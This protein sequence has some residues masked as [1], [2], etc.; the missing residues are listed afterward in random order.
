MNQ[1]DIRNFSIIAHVDHGKSTLS[2]RF[3]EFTGTVQ[4]RDLREQMLD[5]NP[6]ERER[7]V[8]IK[9]APVTMRFK[10]K[11][12]NG[13][14]KIISP[15]DLSTS[16]FHL[17]T[18]N[19]IDTPGHVDFSYE[20]ERS[21]AACEGAI[22]LVDATQ[23]I[24]AQTLA[25]AQ[26]AAELGLTIIP[27][28]NKID[29]E[30]ANRGQVLSEMKEVF[31]YLPHDVSFIS[32]KTGQGVSE[33]L[34]RIVRDVPA[35]HGAPKQPLR[36]LVFNSSF[37]QHLGVIAFVRIVDGALHSGIPLSFLS[38]SLKFNPK[39]IGIFT[40]N[41][42]PTETLDAGQVGYIATGLKD[43]RSVHVGD[44]VTAIQHSAFRIQNLTPLPGYRE[45]KP[46]VYSDVYPDEGVTYQQLQDAVDRLRLSDASL[47]TS[48]IYSPALGAGLRLGFLGLFHLDITKERLGRE[49]GIE[50]LFTLPTV[51]YDVHLTNGEK[52]TVKNPKE[53][54]DPSA[55]T[56]IFEPIAR[57]SLFTPTEF[58]G[59]LMKVLQSRRG[60]YHTTIYLGNR[61]RLLYLVPLSELVSGLFDEIK[62][63]SRGFATLDYE[64]VA[65]QKVSAVKLDIL[66]NNKRVDSLSRIVVSEKAYAIGKLMVEKLK[67]LLPPQQFALPIQAAVGG[68][69]LA[70]ET[71]KAL[72]KDVTAKLYGGDQTRKDKLLK[73]QKKGKK[74]IALFGR[75]SIPDEVFSAMAKI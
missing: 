60:V 65:P 45:P 3:L 28:I 36:A 58:I 12:E 69:I 15:A 17:S 49:Y 4:K 34:S 37:D 18:F 31:G 11:D 59:G 48:P 75:V 16:N 9:L 32:A 70:R 35:P 7:G 13:K 42:T 40:P 64:V 54:P 30:S 53:L 1:E 62:S 51:E 8:T 55:V 22:L 33:L 24:Q 73:K 38:S 39:E 44:T 66:I 26:K 50:T 43:I 20:V 68:T 72:R 21:L 41:R 14:M 2:D 23:G 10:W 61:A 67:D 19:L 46:T 71:K 6:I 74:R 52:L 25:H 5:T 27:A 29:L 63:A 47:A 57:V 56:E